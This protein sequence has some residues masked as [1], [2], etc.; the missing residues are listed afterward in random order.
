[1]AKLC[2]SSLCVEESQC[3]T[4]KILH[5]TDRKIRLFG[6][7]KENLPSSKKKST[8]KQFN[9]PGIETKGI[10][11]L[12]ALFVKHIYCKVIRMKTC[13]RESVLGHFSLGFNVRSAEKFW[14]KSV[15]NRVK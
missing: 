5:K 15:K 4:L 13:A 8:P 11:V 10:S 12:H 6:K 14:V 3:S 2:L 9:E 7:G 1:M